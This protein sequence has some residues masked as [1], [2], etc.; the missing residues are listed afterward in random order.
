MSN[1]SCKKCYYYG[2]CDGRRKCKYFYP[3]DDNEEDKM[4]HKQI[5]ENRS[6]YF[7][8]WIQYSSEFYF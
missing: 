3:V 1:K 5:E 8:E 6:E 4:I 2:S 7:S